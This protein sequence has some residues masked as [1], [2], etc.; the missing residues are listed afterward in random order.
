MK[1][2][3]PTGRSLAGQAV[4]SR[5][6]PR[7]A[8][9]GGLTAS[10]RA[11]VQGGDVQRAVGLEGAPGG[12]RRGGRGGG[13]EALLW[14]C[15]GGGWGWGGVNLSGDYPQSKPQTNGI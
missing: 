12:A 4:P 11:V 2:L 9:Q 15:G 5:P 6:R 8:R 10:P 1:Q 3:A 14:G 7:L 13:K